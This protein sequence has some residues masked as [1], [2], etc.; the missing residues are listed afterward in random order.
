[1][2]VGIHSFVRSRA[3]PCGVRPLLRSEPRD[4]NSVDRVGL[5]ALQVLAG[6]AARAQRVDQSNGVPRCSERS[7]H[8]APVVP[9][10]LHG[11]EQIATRAEQLEQL[12]VT[13]RVLCEAVAFTTT[14]RCSSM[15][16]T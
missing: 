5:G 12:A 2:S 11:D 8:V 10:R 13:G 7:V 14:C 16:A 6:E 4:A 9:R 15:T 1:V 3:L